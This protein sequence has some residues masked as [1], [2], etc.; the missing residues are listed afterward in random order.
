[1]RFHATARSLAARSYVQ[2]DRSP[3]TRLEIRLAE[4]L[5][6][7]LDPCD[8]GDGIEVVHDVED[9][10]EVEMDCDLED[11]G[12]DAAGA[13]QFMFA[14]QPDFMPLAAD[15]DLPPALPPIPTPPALPPVDDDA[16]GTIQFER[17][18][19]HSEPYERIELL[20]ESLPFV[21]VSPAELH[22]RNELLHDA[23]RAAT[24]EPD[25]TMPSWLYDLGEL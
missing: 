15:A 6:A 12:R 24:L 23:L 11:D 20:G 1:M 9:D 21:R 5:L 3:S 16:V 22:E 13:V 19:A 7:T 4:V 8:L 2:L 25:I 17:Q 18:A 10:L 14:A